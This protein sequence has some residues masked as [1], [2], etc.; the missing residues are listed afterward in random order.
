MKKT[1]FGLATAILLGVASFSGPASAF[2]APLPTTGAISDVTAV[3]Y[4]RNANVCTVRTVV[5]RG[6]HGRRVVKKVRVCR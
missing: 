5:T 6:Y 3:Q 2:Q 1:T 4:H